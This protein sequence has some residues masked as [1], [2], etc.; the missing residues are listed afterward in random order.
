MSAA[1]SMAVAGA[2]MLGREFREIPVFQHKD[3]LFHR[4]GLRLKNLNTLLIQLCQSAPSDTRDNNCINMLAIQRL[5][6]IALSMLV[7]L[8]AVLDCCKAIICGINNNERGSRTKMSIYLTIH[9]F[10]L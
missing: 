1:Y 3:I 10:N 2:G 8:V 7:V 4:L 9:T 5:H 6:R